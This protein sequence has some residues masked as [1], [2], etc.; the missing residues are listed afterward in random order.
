MEK[1]HQAGPL[2]RCS[3]SRFFFRT[4]L[5]KSLISRLFRGSLIAVGALVIVDNVFATPVFQDTLGLG[6]D[7]VIYS[8][9]KHID[10]QG[11]LPWRGDPRLAAVHSARRV[12]PYMKHTGGAMSPF[13][14]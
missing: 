5:W 8:A 7:V 12:E 14:A 9:T 10:G 11:P 6:A 4:P 2:L 1:G 3:S 13:N